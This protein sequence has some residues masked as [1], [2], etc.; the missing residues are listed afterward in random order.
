ME[1]HREVNFHFARLTAGAPREVLAPLGEALLA[2]E[3]QRRGESVDAPALLRTA[4]LSLAR[5]LIDEVGA[6]LNAQQQLFL[7]SGAV[8]EAVTLK[9]PA[10]ERVNVE[11]LP[12]GDY[13]GLLGGLVGDF[14]EYLLAPKRR[15]AALATERLAPLDLERPGRYRGPR[16]GGEQQADPRRLAEQLGR[17][18]RQLEEEKDALGA[19]MRALG[20][21][22]QAER[23]KTSLQPAQAVAALA[24]QALK[25]RDDPP[26]LA[27]LKLPADSELGIG[28]AQQ[29]RREAERVLGQLARTKSR[30]LASLKQV[31]SAAAALTKA[32]AADSAP[33]EELV[34]LDAQATKLVDKDYATTNGVLVQAL[35]NDPQRTAWST[36]R[37]LLSENTEKFADPLTECYA[38]PANLVRSIAKIDTLHPNCFPHDADGRP[39]LPPVVIEPGVGQVQWYDDRF[40]L[41]FV[42]TA[43]ARKGS[44]LSLSPLDLAVMRMYGQFLARGDI[45]D[46]RG[47]RLSGNFAADYAGEVES[48]AKVKFT[49]A[50][51]KM[52]FVSASEVKDA[53]GREEAVSDY[54]EFIYSVANG[55]AIPKRITP[56]RIGVMLRYCIIETVE[57]TAA[58]ALRHLAN[59]DP[60][61]VR[62]ILT[63]LAD[64]DKARVVQLISQ[65]IGA[66]RQLG[67]KFRND[68]ALALKEIMGREF[69]A[70]AE[71][72]GLAGGPAAEAAEDDSTAEK[73]PGGGHDYFDV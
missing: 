8:G 28:A 35:I 51:K 24:A 31:R 36:S 15:M 3:A 68:L 14:P 16:E 42:C 61:V 34:V 4:W 29:L 64:R 20:E 56:R 72:A 10:G 22:L 67:S 54:I 60:Q 52:T 21:L 70:D 65:A 50:E 59:Y 7:L 5:W 49:G 45:Y 32:G 57:N 19:A 41:S 33:M 46:Y 58:L 18:L 23:L 47:D 62:E 37:V 53:A 9:S 66:D 55:L 25:H 39:L 13:D 69:A 63:N 1:Q 73:P 71:R 38:T 44:R 48:K 17:Q 11:L 40:I 26:T 27:G 30:L 43:P 12:A 6:E 2:V